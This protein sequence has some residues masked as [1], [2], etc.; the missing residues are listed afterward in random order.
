MKQTKKRKTIE[1]FNGKIIHRQNLVYT[2]VIMQIPTLESTNGNN[3]FLVVIE[4]CG[5]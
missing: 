4:F 2:L 1:S 5:Y 3:Q